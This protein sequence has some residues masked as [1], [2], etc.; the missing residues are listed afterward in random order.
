MNVQPQGMQP[1]V[2]APAEPHVPETEFGKWFLRTE[3]WTVHVL[4]RALADLD[5]LM[6][7][8]RKSFDVVAD[9]GCGYGRSLPKLHERF[10]PKRLIGMD[11]D[12]EM[13]EASGKEVAQ[14][15]IAA[16]FVCCSSSNIALP[17]DSVDLL[18]C[19]QTFHH[20]IDQERAIAEFF[21][22]L[23]PGGV[24]L[25]AESTRR[26]IHSWIIRLLF[27]HPMDVQKTAPEYLAMVR[28]AGFDVP[29]SAVSYPFLWWSREDL[30][31]LE[32]VF[33]IKPRAVREETLINLVGR[34]P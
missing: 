28:G 12:P 18:F 31:I 23:K 4:E 19:H 32:R 3:T 11:I 24:L 16:E 7:P 5:R 9:V 6:P 29:D 25:F 33:R 27:R 20:L 21:R 15:G 17:D 13:I 30:G 8:G 14:H 1:A 34:K 10:A 26:Y 22:V 2:Q